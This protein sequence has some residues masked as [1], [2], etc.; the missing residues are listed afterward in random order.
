[1]SRNSRTE[2]RKSELIKQQ[3]IIA[4]KK[5]EILKKNQSKELLEKYKQQTNKRLVR[6][7]AMIVTVS[8]SPQKPSLS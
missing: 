2:Q 1:M 4:A 6:V 5:L 8:I 7:Q 3:S